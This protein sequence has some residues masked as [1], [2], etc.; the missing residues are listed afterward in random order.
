MNSF[1]TA[2]QDAL[3]QGKDIVMATAVDHLVEFSDSYDV[4][5]SQKAFRCS[6][7]V[8]AETPSMGQFWQA[9]FS[10]PPEELPNIVAQDSWWTFFDPLEHPFPTGV[11]EKL[12][13]GETLVLATVIAKASTAP[14]YAAVKLA[15]DKDGTLYGTLG[16]SALDAGVIQTAQSVLEEYTPRLWECSVSGEDGQDS[17]L[18]ILLDPI[19]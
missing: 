1:Y 7:L 14:Q 10:A 8:T 11:L 18:R 13:G 16:D 12:A 9:V 17:T 2:L 3:N 4:L 19:N 15:V 6:D 5:I